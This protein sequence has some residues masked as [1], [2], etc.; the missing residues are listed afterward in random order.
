MTQ[1]NIYVNGEYQFT[2][3]AKSFEQAEF[4]ALCCISEEVVDYAKDYCDRYRLDYDELEFDD[5]EI[6]NFDYVCDQKEN[7]D[8]EVIETELDD[9]E[10]LILGYIVDGNP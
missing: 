3:L 4:E 10:D 7:P 5:F 1:Y 8:F 9:I 2:T 6:I